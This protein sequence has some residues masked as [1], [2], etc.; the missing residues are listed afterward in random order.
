MQQP[1][2][3]NDFIPECGALL[4]RSRFSDRPSGLFLSYLF[5][6]ALHCKKSV[7]GN[8]ALTPEAAEASL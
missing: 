7:P 1:K 8:S 3:I 4:R 5:E 6:F 2:K